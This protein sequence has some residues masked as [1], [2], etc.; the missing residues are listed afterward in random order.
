M[1]SRMC[2]LTLRTNVITPSGCFYL[3]DGVVA[4]CNVSLVFKHGHVTGAEQ[5][6]VTGCKSE[7]DGHVPGVGVHPIP[8]A[9]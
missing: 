2:M 4:S 1:L 6:G 9:A 7:P 3:Y 5:T 8:G